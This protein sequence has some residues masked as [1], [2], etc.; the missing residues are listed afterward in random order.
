MGNAGLSRRRRGKAWLRR[1]DE[2]LELVG[3]VTLSEL[4]EWGREVARRAI[5]VSQG[6]EMAR[7][8]E[9]ATEILRLGSVCGSRRGGSRRDEAQGGFEEDRSGSSSSPCPSFP[10]F[11]LVLGLI[12]VSE[13]LS[14]SC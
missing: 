1:L 11:S 13:V 7:P 14:E 8:H 2:V 6:K 12:A 10:S 9:I 5:K 4:V 3:P